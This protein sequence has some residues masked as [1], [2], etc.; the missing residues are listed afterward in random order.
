MARCMGW[1][2]PTATA[3]LF[4]LPKQRCGH[5]AYNYP[6]VALGMHPPSNSSTVLPQLHQGA[7]PGGCAPDCAAKN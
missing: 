2:R 1:V 6:V 5:L 3:V 4:G 7:H